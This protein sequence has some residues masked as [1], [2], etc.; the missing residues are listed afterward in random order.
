M[1][2][3]KLLSFPIFLLITF[4]TFSQPIII[5]HNCAFLEPIP[6]WAIKKASDSLHIAYGH[7]SHGSQITYGMKALANQSTQLKGYKGDFYCWDEYHE[8]YGDFPCLDIDNR[9]R[10]GDLGHNGDTT[11]AARTRDYLLNETRAQDINVVMWSW[12]GGCS[13]NTDEGIQAYLDAMNKLEQDFPDITFIYMTGH[14][15]HWSDAT[16]KHNNQ[17]IRDYCIANNKILYDFADIESYD[18]DN[19]YYEFSNDNCDYYDANGNHLGNWAEEWQNSH[20]LN[21]DW[22]Q[23]SA[24]HSKALNGNRKAFAA[25]WLWARLAGWNPQINNIEITHQPQNDTICNNET[26][27]FSVDFNNSDSIRWQYKEQGFAPFKDIFDN[28]IF[29]GATEKT[30]TVNVTNNN[31]LSNEYRCKIYL[32]DTIAYSNVALIYVFDPIPASVNYDDVACNDTVIL[33]G[34]NP[35]PGTCKWNVLSGTAVVTNP[36]EYETQAN[37]LSHGKN[38]FEYITYLYGCNDTMVFDVYR[39]DH[40]S[41]TNQ[42]TLLNA[43][44][45]ENL[46]ITTNISG[47]LEFAQWYKDEM[48]LNNGA[49]YSGANSPVL[50]IRNIENTDKGYY[51][52]ELRGYC[53][54][55]LSDSVFVDITNAT[56]DFDTEKNPIIYPNPANDL[57]Y[58]KS[59][60]DIKSIGVLDLNGNKIM[61]INKP[62]KH[63]DISKLNT[64]VFFIRIETD[65]NIFYSKITK[66]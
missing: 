45:G 39:Y 34:S 9:F 36:T 20:T 62:P 24:A 6:E 28:D 26:A 5:N 19:N 22:Y 40:L 65:G 15:D 37:N 35:A 18:P 42:D 41:L 47:D 21:V 38:T 50:L 57:L 1:K 25:W 63:I 60:V 53:N 51:W 46:S 43:T 7:T 10:P 4:A 30:L 23:C 52:C 29:T 66:M 27:M 16:L 32:G 13:D 33:K 31:I 12:C 55:V 44:T 17:L 61:E 64:G 11:W 3:M 59:N 14:L 54:D 58:I 48:I 2:L 56:N 49:K 8:V